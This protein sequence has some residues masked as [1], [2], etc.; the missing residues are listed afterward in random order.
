MC[1]LCVWK[2]IPTLFEKDTETDLHVETTISPSPVEQ[3]KP[4]SALPVET[5]TL[6]ECSVRLRS[7][8]S[9]LFTEKKDNKSRS[10]KKRDSPPNTTPVVSTAQLDSV[11][12]TDSAAVVTDIKPDVPE[13]DD[14]PTQGD[15]SLKVIL[16]RNRNRIIQLKTLRSMDVACVKPELTQLR[17]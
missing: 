7:L 16:L 15:T 14:A 12:K 10:A 9:I 1:I 5:F 6:K 4:K 17:S 3:Q 8:E 2:Q 11:P 13:E